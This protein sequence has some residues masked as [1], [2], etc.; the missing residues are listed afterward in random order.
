[1]I[2]VSFLFLVF[3][4]FSLAGGAQAQGQFTDRAKLLEEAKKEGKVMVYIS[5]NAADANALKAAF[6]KKYPFIKMEYYRGACTTLRVNNLEGVRQV[7]IFTN[8]AD[9]TMVKTKKQRNTPS[10]RARTKERLVTLAVCRTAS[11]AL[12]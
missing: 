1:M 8:L 10:V 3:T 4:V 6:E 2:I 11:S 5:S 12:S 7:T 9:H